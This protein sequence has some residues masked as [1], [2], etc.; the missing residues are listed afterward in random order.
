MKLFEAILHTGNRTREN[1]KEQS[2]R[3]NWIGQLK[4]EDINN[5]LESGKHFDG[6]RVA[7]MES[8]Y[9]KEQYALG[10]WNPEDDEKVKEAIYLL[11]QDE[12]FG[13]YV[14]DREGFDTVWA[15][16]E[17][18]P[19]GTLNFDKEEVEIIGPLGKEWSK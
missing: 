19:I 9:S 2:K 13:T 16:G 17:Y 18:E 14:N 11:E 1:I 5:I 6:V 12:Y 15:A 10:F 3:E 8:F 4:E 7:V